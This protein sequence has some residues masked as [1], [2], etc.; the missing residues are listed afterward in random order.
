MRELLKL[1]ITDDHRIY[2]LRGSVTINLFCQRQTAFRQKALQ[3]IESHN[4]KTRAVTLFFLLS[5]I[6]GILI[7]QHLA[8]LLKSRL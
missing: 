8:T 2:C 7:S 3:E 1:C 5:A 4:S 6:P